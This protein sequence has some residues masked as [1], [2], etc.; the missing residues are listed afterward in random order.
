MD[1]PSSGGSAFTLVGVELAA[2]VD[3]VVEAGEGRGPGGG[4]AGYR[5]RVRPAGESGVALLG[6]S[7]VR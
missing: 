1:A 5:V 3:L 2:R 7:L 4:S 6:G